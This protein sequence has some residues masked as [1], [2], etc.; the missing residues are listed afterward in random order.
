VCAVYLDPREPFKGIKKSP[1]Q[2]SVTKMQKTVVDLELKAVDQKF[3]N[4][5][6]DRN[7]VS[8]IP[9]TV[10]KKQFVQLTADQAKTFYQ[11]M[12]Q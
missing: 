12:A 10:N 2:E 7:M 4:T 6:F 3:I 9:H 1:F 5:V 8:A 11:K